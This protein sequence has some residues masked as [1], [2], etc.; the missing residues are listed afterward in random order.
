MFAQNVSTQ[1]DVT[2]D[3]SLGAKIDKV[4]AICK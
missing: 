4:Q 2:L 1:K 3:L